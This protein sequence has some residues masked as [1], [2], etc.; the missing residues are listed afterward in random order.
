MRRFLSPIL[1]CNNRVFILFPAMA[2]AANH[3][4]AR[5]ASL[6]LDTSAR[7]FTGVSVL[8]RLTVKIILR[9]AQSAW[10]RHIQQVLA[11]SVIQRFF[12]SKGTKRNFRA[13]RLLLKDPGIRARFNKDNLDD[14]EF[15]RVLIQTFMRKAVRFAIRRPLAIS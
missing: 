5:I 15:K 2:S 4:E 14:D 8:Q 13:L 12:R 9:G 6:P 1:H 10:R 11:V 7:I 3:S